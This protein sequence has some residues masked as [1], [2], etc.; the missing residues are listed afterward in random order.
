MADTGAVTINED[1][2][3]EPLLKSNDYG[4]ESN[5][6]VVEGVVNCRGERVIDRSKFGGWKSASLIIVVDIAETVAYN[7]VSSNLISYLTGPL[8]QSTITAA[9]NVNIWVGAGWMLPLLGAVVADSYLGRF[10]TI[11]FSCLIYILVGLFLS[12]KQKV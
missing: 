6:S 7:G 12:L 8:R 4:G 11:L 2:Y 5:G 3:D 10:R 9:A 1:E